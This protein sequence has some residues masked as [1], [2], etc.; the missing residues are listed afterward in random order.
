LSSD[1][2]GR[3]KNTSWPEEEEKGELAS[4]QSKKKRGSPS[5]PPKNSKGESQGLGLIGRRERAPEEEEFPLIFSKRGIF[6]QMD[7]TSEV[8]G[9]H[10]LPDNRRER[11][12]ILIEDNREVDLPN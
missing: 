3:G 10:L 6:L 8:E 5:R 11:E 1:W 2:V 7:T 12:E 9:S 4:G